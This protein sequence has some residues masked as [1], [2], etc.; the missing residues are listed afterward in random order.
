MAFGETRD[1]N[2]EIS[3]ENMSF[4]LLHS[5]FL[6]LH[7]EVKTNVTPNWTNV[8]YHDIIQSVNCHFQH[9]SVAKATLFLSPPETPGMSPGDPIHVSWQEVRFRSVITSC[10]RCSRSFLLNVFSILS[11][12][13]K[14]RDKLTIPRMAHEQFTQWKHGFA[15]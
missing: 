8:I 10:T 4:S 9:T 3:T 7:S 5:V 14:H 15:V 1:L 2:N 12:A 6:W 13:W 11:M